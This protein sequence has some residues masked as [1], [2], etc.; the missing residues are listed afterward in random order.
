MYHM[1]ACYITPSQIRNK[2]DAD[3]IGRL[4]CNQN[5][6]THPYL[7][8]AAPLSRASCAARRH[9]RFVCVGHDVKP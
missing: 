7:L 5:T 6:F 4:N 3:A 9:P 8:F 2:L 1:Y